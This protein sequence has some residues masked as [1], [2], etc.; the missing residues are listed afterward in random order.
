MF[1]KSVFFLSAIGVL[2]FGQT[3]PEGRLMRFPDIHGDKIAFSY[4]GDLWLA[5]RDGGVARR[6]TTHPG[7]ELFPKFSPDG[8]WLAFTGQYDGNYNVYIIPAEG[9]APKQLTF[10]PGG[11]PISERMGIHN[12]VINW[13]PD[14]KRILFL[15]RRD[16]YN[17]WFG[18][19]YSVSIDGGLPEPLALPKGGMTSFAPDGDRIAYNQIFRNFRTWKRYQGG[20]AQDISIYDFK[21]NEI[22]QL[23]HE[24]WT[25]TFP[26]WHG[27]TIYFDSDRGPEHRLNLYSYSLKSRKIRQ[28]THFTDFDVNWPSLGPDAIIF[29]NG[30]YLYT[31]DLNNE[32]PRKLTI[33]LPGDMELARKRWVNVSPLI[34]DFDLSPDGKRA[35]FSARGDIYTVPAKEGSI[36]QITHTPGIRE[37]YVAW[38]P[39]GRWIAYMSDRTGADELYIVPQDGLG[40]EVRITTGG[41]SFRMPPVWSPD[42]TRLAYSDKDAKLFYVDINNKSPVL[43]DQGRYGEITDYAWSPDSKWI[44]YAKP[45]ANTYSV[46]SLYSTAGRNS[47]PVTTDFY[48]SSNPWF[49]PEGKY[50]YF[51]SNRDYNEVLGNYDIEFAN[52]KTT[53]IYV[54]TLRAD[55]PSPFPVLSDEVKVKKP[56]ELVTPAAPGEQPAKGQPPKEAP[57]KAGGVEAAASGPPGPRHPRRRLP[58]SVS[59]CRVSKPAQWPSRY[60]RATCA[61]SMRRRTWSFTRRCP[62]SAFPARSP[63]KRLP[64]MSSI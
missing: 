57:K 24:D 37:K 42:S 12:E 4:G 33:Y 41:D 56:D 55:L 16:T 5:G 44:A 13:F 20:M 26:M 34:A 30:G 60:L 61:V 49:D 8:K 27:D 64:S 40:P 36:R 28:L 52:P 47:A 45:V 1:T 22:Q 63:V 54:V 18:R 32:K 9:G 43:I 14:S 31:F 39:D 10:H 23:P 35:V 2:S 62:R 21:T 3:L 7:Q 29:E 58:N 19:L 51:M 50:L 53:R 17:T 59:I 15:S 25:D 6:I 11:D 46:I 38:S 48:S